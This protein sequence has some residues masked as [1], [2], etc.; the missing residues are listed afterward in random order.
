MKTQKRVGIGRG[1]FG[2]AVLFFVLLALVA[3][4]GGVRIVSGA[5]VIPDATGID[6]YEQEPNDTPSS[7]TTLMRNI[8]MAGAIA[9]QGD[10]D[11]FV[12]DVVAGELVTIVVHNEGVQV[13]LLK[14]DGTELHDLGYYTLHFSFRSSSNAT[15]YLRMDDPDDEQ[16]DSYT[17][18]IEDGGPPILISAPEPGRVHGLTFSPG[19][20]LLHRI[21]T[22]D[23]TMFFDASD[24]GLLRNV[25]AFT[26]NGDL[27]AGVQGSGQ[28][29]LVLGRSQWIP[30][31]GMVRPQDII[32]FSPQSLGAT[33]TG[34]FEEGFRGAV[35]GLKDP[36]EAIDA[37]GAAEAGV[38][39]HFLLSTR[40]NYRVR[41][42]FVEREET[43]GYC[44]GKDEDTLSL[45]EDD[46]AGS[47]NHMCIRGLEGATV[48]G[49]GREDITG[50]SRGW[51]SVNSPFTIGGISGG[52][53]DILQLHRNDDQSY[54]VTKFWDGRSEGF[55]Y[56]LDGIEVQRGY[57]VDE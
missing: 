46:E 48:P 18:T 47:Q 8:A 6:A 40:G 52:A 28:L 9:P 56:A 22:D 3:G 31:L 35:I 29:G 2:A 45:W 1:R 19:D 54:D 21:G 37:L 25:V 11:Y 27:D 20:I 26:Y 41:A 39:Y 4:L 51:I 23:W 49:L 34:S 55:H 38:G 17:L 14:A 5:G 42:W 13:Q 57:L 12:F 16:G 10:V 33:T 50:L 43:I 24:V 7:A 53:D 36:G 15:Y 30:A 44:T 32:I